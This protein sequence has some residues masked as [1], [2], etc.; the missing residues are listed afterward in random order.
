MGLGKIV[1]E[2]HKCVRIFPLQ[3]HFGGALICTLPK[4]VYQ[5]VYGSCQHSWA[6]AQLTLKPCSNEE[7]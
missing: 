7:R 2:W 5:N 1:E 3:C 6:S 4:S